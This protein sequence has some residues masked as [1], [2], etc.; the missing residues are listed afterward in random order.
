MYL[1]INEYEKVQ[2]Q[3]FFLKLVK[4]NNWTCVP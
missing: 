4:N 1:K 2:I 3:K